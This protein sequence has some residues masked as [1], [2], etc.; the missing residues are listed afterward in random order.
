M[1]RSLRSNSRWKKLQ[2]QQI[3]Q[4]DQEL[5]TNITNCTETKIECFEQRE[6]LSLFKLIPI[7]QHHVTNRQ[8]VGQE[9]RSMRNTRSSLNRPN[10][11]DDSNNNNQ[12][13]I[14]RKIVLGK[15]SL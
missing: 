6:F 13:D 11:N 2:V 12:L 4:V 7:K 15:I 3:K 9:R 8:I 5:R 14:H 10:T 1:P